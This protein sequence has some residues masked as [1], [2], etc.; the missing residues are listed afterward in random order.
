MAT[1][2]ESKTAEITEQLKEVKIDD[3]P[4]LEDLTWR[5]FESEKDLAKIMEMMKRDLSEPYPIYTYRYFVH[6]W[7]ELTLIA[8]YKG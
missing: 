5:C 2:E 6:Q 4:K 3:L 8:E 7:P 1:K